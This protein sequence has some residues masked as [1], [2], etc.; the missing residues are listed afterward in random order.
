M[1]KSWALVTGGSGGIGSK[2]SLDLARL[3]YN[4]VIFYVKNHGRVGETIK[5]LDKIGVASKSICVD[6]SNYNLV[7][8]TV[9][10]L[11][12]DLGGFDVL[13]NCAGITKDA[14]LKDLTNSSWNEV[15]DTNLKSCFNVTKPVVSSMIKKN[16]GRIINIS[17]VIAQTG[18]IGQSNYSA[19][20]SGL[21]GFTKS[22][23]LE[24][25][26]WNIT[27]N[28]ICPGFIKTSMTEEIPDKV[29]EKIIKKIPKLKFGLPNDVSR[30]VCFLAS[31]NAEYI[32]GSTINIDGGFSMV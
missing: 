14:L 2:I 22:L 3:G 24:Y 31:P 16:Y 7:K 4:V 8:D 17:S 20:K 28:T 6:V 10:D 30:A 19:S 11:I 15:I 25:A 18:A 12:L 32:T 26:K 21:I 23:A 5:K 27:V 13:V 29:K 1:I 9:N